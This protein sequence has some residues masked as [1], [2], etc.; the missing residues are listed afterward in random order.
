MRALS[1]CIPE[2]IRTPFIEDLQKRLGSSQMPSA[3]TIRYYELSLDMALL[4]TEQE[5]FGDRMFD[6]RTTWSD[7]SP[8]KGV[9]W[10]WSQDVIVR[11]CAME[12]VFYAVRYITLA[13]KDIMDGVGM[14]WKHRS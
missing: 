12:E 5:L 11:R 7:S 14:K 4:L 13:I 6:L 3:S 1:L 8:I 9:D 10:I 2:F